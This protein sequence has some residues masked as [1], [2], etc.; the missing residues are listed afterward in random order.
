[1]CNTL[2]RLH[3]RVQG[4]GGG[5]GVALDLANLVRGGRDL[6]EGDEVRASLG[7]GG[8]HLLAHGDGEAGGATGDSKGAGRFLAS[9][10]GRRKGVVRASLDRAADGGGLAGACHLE[11]VAGGELLLAL[12]NQK[13][14]LE[15]QGHLTCTQ[16]CEGCS[17]QQSR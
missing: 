11:G 14:G 13:R 8:G 15:L 9:S 7:A 10:R 4:E 2:L 1:M 16:R 17:W 3:L 12:V 5:T 6:A